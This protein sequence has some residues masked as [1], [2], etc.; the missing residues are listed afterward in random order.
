MNKDEL[1]KFKDELIKRRKTPKYY[2]FA[3]HGFDTRGK[4]QT[5]E[6]IYSQVNTEAAIKKFELF[7]ENLVQYLIEEEINFNK[8]ELSLWDY[9]YL[10]AKDQSDYSENEEDYKYDLV[11]DLKEALYNIV[12]LGINIYGTEDYE[13]NINCDFLDKM[14]RELRDVVLGTVNFNEFINGVKALGYDFSIEN[15]DEYMHNIAFPKGNKGN[16]LIDFSKESHHTL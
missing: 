7:L 6:E 3:D 12:P 4:R 14:P 16:C 1:I 5:V 2:V 8:I 9:Y 11:H 10:P 13:E 15:F